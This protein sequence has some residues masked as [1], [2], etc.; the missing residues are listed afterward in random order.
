MSYT[1]TNWTNGSGQPISAENL[2][3]IEDGI[4]NNDA[5]LTADEAKYDALTEI[6]VKT[7]TINFSQNA[8]SQSTYTGSDT[9]A[10]YYPIGVVGHQ[11]SGTGVGQIV[12]YS[13]YLSAKSSGACTCTVGIRNNNTGSAISGSIGVRVLWQKEAV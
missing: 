2:N 12:P 1:K 4:F 8:A 11:L 9:K 13:I 6:T 3:N 10:G 5:R 7:L